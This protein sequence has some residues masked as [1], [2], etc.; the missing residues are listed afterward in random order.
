MMISGHTEETIRQAVEKINQRFAG[1]ITIRQL[2]RHGTTGRSKYLD[3]RL[4]VAGTRDKSYE[5]LPG[6]HVS[7]TLGRY[8]RADGRANHAASWDAHGE[9]FVALYHINPDTV[10]RTGS[11]ANGSTVL[12]SRDDLRNHWR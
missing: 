5:I 9:F 4:G 12:K 11:I 3:V 2:E 1:N 7:R 8:G 6:V 10:I